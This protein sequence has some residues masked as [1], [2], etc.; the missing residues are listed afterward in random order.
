MTMADGGKTCAP[1]KPAEVITERDR[2]H[3]KV[4]QVDE[5]TTRLREELVQV[6]N[7]NCGGVGV[8]KTAEQV[9]LTVPLAESI[10]TTSDMAD[11][12]IEVLRDILAR[13]EI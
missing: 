2:L 13:L 6:L 3:D 10:A 5:M 8:N 4:C 12:I 7:T 9:N 11:K 1:R